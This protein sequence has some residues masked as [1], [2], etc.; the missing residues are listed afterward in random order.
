MID[1]LGVLRRIMN[2]D[3]NETFDP[4]TDSLEAIANAL[5]V[6]PS[7]GLWMFGIVDATQVASAI[8]I[9]T[10][11]LQNVPNDTLEGQFWMQVI[12]NTNAPGTAPEGEI[13]HITN[14]VQGGALQTFTVDDFTANVEA[15]DLVIIFHESL[16]S[17]QIL[18]SGTLTLSSATVPEDNLR[19]EVDNYFNGCLLMPTEGACR[20]QPRRIVDWA[21]GGGGPGTGIFTLDPNNPF[22][23]VPGLVD[24]VIIG[25][26]TEFVPAADAVINRTPA[27]VI[28][29]KADIAAAG[30]IKAVNSILALAKQSAKQSFFMLA[31]VTTFTNLNNFES[32]DL[33]GYENGFF[34]GGAAGWYV[35][36]VRDD[37][38]AGAAPTGEYRLI[39]GY[40]SATGG[41]VHNAFSANLAVGDQVMLIHP[42]L[43]EILTIRGGAETLESLDDELDA[44]LDLAGGDALTLL[45]TGAEQTLY[46]YPA[47]ADMPGAHPFFFAGL[48]IDWTGLNFGGGENTSIRFYELVDGVGAANLRLISTEVFLVAALPVPAVTLHPRNANTDIQPTPGYYRQGIRITAQQALVGGGWNTLTYSRID[49]VRGT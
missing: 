39:T 33:V 9:I 26:Q 17:H 30:I 23:G 6:G 41:I 38:G 19:V 3:V 15:G 48:K 36:V 35:F 45:M 24:Y 29:N 21:V 31:D 14:F 20:F 18:G 40:V 7:V 5:G 28:G 1:L 44:M 12:Y 11:N 49:G 37:V 27:D 4:T 47:A 10:N 16:L 43:Y 25:D 22:T 8:T 13:R 42:M 46:E 2:M 32:L 34:G